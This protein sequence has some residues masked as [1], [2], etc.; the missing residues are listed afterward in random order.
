[1]TSANGK[2]NGHGPVVPVEIGEK[3]LAVKNKIKD[4]VPYFSLFRYSWT[5]FVVLRPCILELV[6]VLTHPPY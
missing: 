5:L 1:M 6:A 4:T 2:A 3:K